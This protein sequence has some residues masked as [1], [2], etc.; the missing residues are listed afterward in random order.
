MGY[1]FG[2]A[3]LQLTESVEIHLAVNGV[4]FDED[5]RVRDGGHVGTLVHAHPFVHHIPL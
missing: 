5:L 4:A 3:Y 1:S 2:L